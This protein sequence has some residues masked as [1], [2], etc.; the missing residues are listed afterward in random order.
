MIQIWTMQLQLQYLCEVMKNIKIDYNDEN[1]KYKIE[2]RSCVGARKYQQDQA[3]AY[4]DKNKLLAL[5]CDGMG[6]CKDGGIA[7]KTVV[8]KMQEYYKKYIEKQNI[9]PNDFLY[10]A[11]CLADKAVIENIGE[12]AG[13]TTIS[14]VLI[15]D[16]LLYWLS[17]GD[18]RIYIFRADESLQVTR[19]HNYFLQLNELKKQKIISEKFYSKEKTRGSQLISYLGK[20]NITLFDLTQTAFGLQK[21]DKLLLATDGV[22]QFLTENE[23]KDIFLSKNDIS[24]KADFLIKKILEFSKTEFQDNAT[25]IIVE[26]L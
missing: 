11:M 21:G 10:N 25:F 7:S 17:V 24:N 23:I 8:S 12:K 2:A 6:G 1:L 4:V 16:K 22:F 19:E 18:S 5:I 3:Y 13:G 26:I 20:G 15:E 9:L 14:A